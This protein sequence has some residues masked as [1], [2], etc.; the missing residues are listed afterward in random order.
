MRIGFRHSPE[1]IQRLRERGRAQFADPDKRRLHGEL[2]SRKMAETSLHVAQL[3]CLRD[4]WLAACPKARARFL[5]EL[6]ARICK[7]EP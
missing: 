5:L 2:T 3:D 1:T 4:A 6:H 7:G